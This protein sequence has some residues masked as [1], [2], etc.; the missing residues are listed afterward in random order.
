MKTIRY[1]AN[2]RNLFDKYYNIFIF[3]CLR[4]NE[5]IFVDFCLLYILYNY[6]LFLDNIII[7][8]PIHVCIYR[9]VK[10]CF[11]L[12]IIYREYNILQPSIAYY[13]ME[14]LKSLDH[15]LKIQI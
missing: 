9:F 1:N 8:I 5:D 14:N 7:F 15:S 10:E 13:I 3:V 4:K 12:N 2:Q 6:S 11:F